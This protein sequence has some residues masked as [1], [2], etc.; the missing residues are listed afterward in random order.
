MPLYRI[1]VWVAVYAATPQKAARRLA[2]D[3]DNGLG[4]TVEYW[5]VDHQDADE[6]TEAQAAD[7]FLD[8]TGEPY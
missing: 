6:I 8:A 1:P 7:L 5:Y 4:Q 3:V 2:E